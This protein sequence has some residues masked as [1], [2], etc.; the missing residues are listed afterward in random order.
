MEEII[1]KRDFIDYV[2]R[3]NASIV[4]CTSMSNY[5]IWIVRDIFGNLVSYNVSNN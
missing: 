2:F 4:S 5:S 1:S 3:Y